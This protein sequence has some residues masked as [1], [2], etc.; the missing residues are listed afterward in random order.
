MTNE[1]TRSISAE[2][3]KGEVGSG[4]KVAH[5]EL[6]PSRKGSPAII[7]LEAGKPYILAD[8]EGPAVIQS[9][10][11]TTFDK[12]DYSPYVLRDLVFRIYWDGEVNPSVEVPLGDFFCNGFAKKYMVNSLPIIVNP[13]GGYN[14]Y[15]PMPFSKKTL[16]TIENQHPV[17]ISS[18]FY[19]INYSLLDKIVDNVGYFHAFW[20][21]EN[22]TKKKVDYTI[23]DK[24][25]GKG[26]YIGTFLAWTALEGHWYG[27]GE[28]KFYIDDDRQ[29]PTICGTGTEDYF[30][31]A[32]CFTD[33]RGYKDED[34]ITYSTPFLG[35]P[36][37]SKT[38]K[39]E[40]GMPMH[41]MYRWHI[42]DPIRFDNRLKVTIQQIGYDLSRMDGITERS[43]DI[44]SVA[45]WYQSEPHNTFNKLPE[46]EDRWPR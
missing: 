9:I 24:I 7:P 25:S 15:F 5:P 35:Y 14:C 29:Y 36:Y 10:W 12:T 41:A 17:D 18:F 32:W 30:G 34:A 22:P 39:G 28:I 27:E 23:V 46:P 40:T 1:K 3:P 45:Y 37:C 19:Q 13:H 38:G 44:S 20:N 42:P 43:D 8:I 21:R 16:I 2:N 6:G 31:G 26:Q 4:G 33:K 11:I